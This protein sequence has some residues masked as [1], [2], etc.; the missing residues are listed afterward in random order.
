MT[1]KYSILLYS[2]KIKNNKPKKTVNLLFLTI[3]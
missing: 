2:N 1:I 3:K